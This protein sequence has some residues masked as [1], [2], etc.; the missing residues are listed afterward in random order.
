VFVLYQALLLNHISTILHYLRLASGQ[1]AFYQ[2]WKCFNNWW[3]VA[4]SIIIDYSLHCSGGN[5]CLQ[6]LTSS[7]RCVVKSKTQSQQQAQI[8]LVGFSPIKRPIRLSAVEQ[9]CKFHCASIR[10]TVR[11]CS[12]TES[13]L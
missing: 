6:R 10:R 9:N 8:S 7:L 4:W 5:W 13:K 1:V 11:T 3:R 12:P 2:I